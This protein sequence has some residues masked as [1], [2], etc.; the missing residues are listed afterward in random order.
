MLSKKLSSSSIASAD[1]RGTYGAGKGR[2]VGICGRS[3][4][5]S[6]WRLVASKRTSSIDGDRALLT[7]SV[8]LQYSLPVFASER[9]VEAVVRR[10]RS[11]CSALEHAGEEI[12]A[13][14]KTGCVN[15]KTV[16]RRDL[17]KLCATGLSIDASSLLVAL[18]SPTMATGV[19][20]GNT[21]VEIDTSK[22]E[23]GSGIRVLWRKQPVFIRS[24]TPKEVA[25]AD[26]APTEPLRDPQ[27]L[28][29]RTKPGHQNWL[30]TMG[31]CTHLGCTL[32]GITANENRGSYGGYVCPCHGSQYDT[33]G[34]VRSGPAP[35]NL[36]IP[37]YSFRSSNVVLIGA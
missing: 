37:P 18:D 6:F 1:F 11:G 31:V 36:E 13:L 20:S 8:R 23:Q 5:A 33:A 9:I 14:R 22:I 7:T 29:E 21:H 27:T 15:A 28:A 34:R 12:H 2:D 4:P 24:L 16:R 25:E 3:G 35:L 10:K 30:I 26:A 32:L 19:L 17:V